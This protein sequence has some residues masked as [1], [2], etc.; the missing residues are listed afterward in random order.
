M[1]RATGPERGDSALFLSQAADAADDRG[2]D[3][4]YDGRNDHR[5]PPDH[6]ASADDRRVAVGDDGTVGIRDAVTTVN[7]VDEVDESLLKLLDVF[8]GDVRKRGLNGERGGDDDDGENH[9]HGEL[10]LGSVNF[11]F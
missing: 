4:Q 6:L 8:I 2:D 7:G 10:H 1:K 3:G 9:S 5:W 11:R